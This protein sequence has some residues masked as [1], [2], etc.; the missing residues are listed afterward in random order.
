MTTPTRL[1]KSEP[2]RF[3]VY[4]MRGETVELDGKRY[5]IPE[6]VACQNVQELA[7]FLYE[8]RVSPLGEPTPPRGALFGYAG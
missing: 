7:I 2:M 6:P 4:L 8:H 3:P 5:T 1:A